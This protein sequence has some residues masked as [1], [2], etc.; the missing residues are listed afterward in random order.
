MSNKIHVSKNLNIIIF[1]LMI[2]L[3]FIND[4][5]DYIQFFY[6]YTLGKI[7]LFIFTLLI[8]LI[9]LWKLKKAKITK[10][11]LL[12]EVFSLS[13][14]RGKLIVT[15]FGILILCIYKLSVGLNLL[16]AISLILSN[17]IFLILALFDDQKTYRKLVTKKE[18]VKEL[19][20]FVYQYSLVAEA[21]ILI[22]ILF[23]IICLTVFPLFSKD[24]ISVFFNN[25]L[26][27]LG[28]IF[29][30]S[31]CI[32]WLAVANNYIILNILLEI[33]ILDEINEI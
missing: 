18:Y 23:D 28:K 29:L 12:K 5:A 11:T 33:G 21:V 19:H 20:D 22:Y 32:L 8:F 24:F 27:F 14:K 6:R 16:E 2:I 25:F 9:T 30:G 26:Y 4:I 3:F 13:N 1:V 31:Y 10:H 17:S 7:I 15:Q